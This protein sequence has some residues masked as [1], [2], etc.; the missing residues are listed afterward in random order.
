MKK[1]TSNVSR[2][3]VSLLMS[4]ALT[5]TLVTPAAFATEVV[6]G[7]GTTIV[8]GNT[9]QADANTSGDTE[10][11]PEDDEII[12]DE[13]D[14]DNGD[15]YDVQEDTLLGIS[16]YAADAWDGKT[17]D[18]TWYD[19]SKNEFE[20]STAAQLA[21]L[22]QLVNSGTETFPDKIIKLTADIDL[23]GKTWTP[24]GNSIKA[25]FAF[26]GGFYGQGHI[27]SNL[28]VPDTYC[29]G[30][31]GNVKN[32]NSLIQDL[33][34][35]GTVMASEIAGDAGDFSVGG[36]CCETSG[37]IQNC[38]FYGKIAA[39]EYF[40]DDVDGY[41]GGVVGDG[42][43]VNCWF[44]STDAGSDAGVTGNRTATNCY[45]NVSDSAKGE[46]RASEDFVNGTVVGLLNDNL[47]EGCK[48]WVQG[49]E[50]PVF[51][52]ADEAGK[53]VILVPFFPD[54]ACAGRVAVPG[55]VCE[56]GRYSVTEDTVKLDSSYEDDIYITTDQSGKGAKPL[57]PNGYALTEDTTF[58][59][60][61]KD[62]FDATKWYENGSCELG[63][64][65]ELKCF[66]NLVNRKV[67]SFA[68][69][70]IVLTAD[71]DLNNAAWTP[72]GSFAS[73]ENQI[74]FEGS[75]NGK[76][77]IVSGLSATGD[78]DQALFGYVGNSTVVENLIVI[79]TVA[80]SGT[81]R[82]A[83]I[84]ARNIGDAW[85]AGNGQKAIVQNCGFYGTVTAQEASNGINSGG[86]VSNCWYYYTGSDE[87]YTTTL[88]GNQLNC[89]DSYTNTVSTQY[90]A[91]TITAEQFEG[92]K[93]V[94]DGKT[95]VGLLNLNCG[96]SGSEWA[97]GTDYPVFAADSERQGKKL[98]IAPLFPDCEFTVSVE[99]EGVSYSAER[100]VYTITN[101]AGLVKLTRSDGKKDLWVSADA[102]GTN[103]ARVSD[104]GY[105]LTAQRTTLYYGT[106][107]DLSADITWW[108][109]YQTQT[110]Y[111]IY[112][113]AALRGIARLVNSGMVA[114]GFKGDLLELRGVPNA[115]LDLSD[116]DYEPIGTSDHPFRGSFAGQ[117]Y[118]GTIIGTVTTI[119]TGLTISGDYANVGL[120]GVVDS[121]TIQYVTIAD[122]TTTKEIEKEDGTKETVEVTVPAGTVTGSGNVGSIV[123]WL[124][125]GTVENCMS[126]AVV[127]GSSS[128]AV[129]GGLVGLNEGT[130]SS[131][132]YYNDEHI[133]TLVVGKTDSENA[134]VK[135]CFYL[136]EDGESAFGEESDTGARVNLEFEVG[137]VTYELNG[138]NGY[139]WLFDTVTKRPT[140]KTTLYTTNV[141]QL[142]L[143]AEDLPKDATAEIKLGDE[144]TIVLTK[145]NIQ[146]IYGRPYSSVP[147]TVESVT[148]GYQVVFNP[149]P[150]N[151]KLRI[152][153]D[154]T[155][156]L[157][158]ADISW[159]VGHENDVEY[160]LTTASQLEGFAIL[161]NGTA[162]GDISFKDKTIKLGN[163]IEL[164]GTWTPIG[165][166]SGGHF[167]E[168]TFDGQKHTIKGLRVNTDDA[169]AGLFG[170]V[171]HGTVKNL[172]VEGSVRSISGTNT[173]GIV[174]YLYQG[175]VENCTNKAEVTAVMG[176]VG[177][178]VGHAY[179]GNGECRIEN[180]KNNAAVT[181]T[182]NDVNGT[183]VG[184]IVGSA[185]DKVIV[186]LCKN[187][188]NVTASG[189]KKV[190]ASGIGGRRVL[191]SHNSGRVEIASG[192]ADYLY[193]GGI[194]AEGFV[195]SCQNDG[196]VYINAMWNG[197]QGF[198]Y[199]GGI[200]GG[201]T[202][203]NSYNTAA[204]VN[205]FTYADSAVKL[206]NGVAAGIA[207]NPTS[208]I[209][210]CYNIGDVSST[211]GE[212]H[213]LGGV[214]VPGVCDSGAENSYYVCKLN[215]EE[216]MKYVSTAGAE[217]D[218]AYNETDKTYM[219]GDK[220]LVD[221][222]NE[223][224]S[225]G[226]PWFVNAEKNIILPTFILL[227]N[228]D[229]HTACTGMK[230]VY[231][232]YE[233]GDG[234]CRTATGQPRKDTIVL[235]PDENGTIQPVSYT[236]LNAEAAGVGNEN[237]TF[238]MWSDGSS[239]YDAGSTIPLSGG[240]D[241]ITL[242]ATNLFVTTKERINA[243]VQQIYLALGKQIEFFERA[244]RPMEA[245]R[246]KQRVEYDLEM[247]KE[248]GYCPGIENYSRY[249]DGRAAGTRP[250][251]LIDYFPKDYLMVV[252]E[253]HVTLPQVHA[254]FGGDR[255]RKENLVEYGFRLPA[256][257]DNRPLTFSEF[258]QLQGTS[259]YVSATPA[260]YELMK[261]EGVIVEQLI[262]PT[263]LVDP[264][265]EVRV[266]LNQ[267][268]DLIGEI[269]KR[270]KNDDKVLVTTIT[271]RMAEE[272]SK[273]FDR[274]GVRNRYIHS[275][276]D[277]LERIQ[278][279]EDLR[280]GMFD[281]LV[282]VN[283]LREGLDLPEVALVAILDADKEG[284]LRNVRSLTQI[285]GRAAR[286]SQGNVILYADTCTDSMRYAIEQS[287]RRREKQVR[288]NMEHEML[289]RQAQKSG[290][291]QS[292]LLAGRVDTSEVN[293]TAYPIAEDHYAAAADVQKN[294]TAS[295]NIDAL[296]DKAREEMERAAK[297]LDF[298]AAA[299]F[300]DRMY[301]LQKL[302]EE[303]RNQNSQ[304]TIHN[305]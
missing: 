162:E 153:T 217:S 114:D 133:G 182:G 188:G 134:G 284:F 305:S 115:T 283:L 237:G 44:Y 163:D 168:G 81:G 263:G 122:T 39:D 124:Q 88:S 19:D 106:E 125:S 152:G 192:T 93:E 118:G 75:F 73:R 265:L 138:P 90:G 304:F 281:V 58:Y 167:F 302:R 38:G 201:G 288:Y 146:Y 236:V 35:T 194:S 258:E 140:L 250:F 28:Y 97:Q 297:S 55:A 272:L 175:T 259:I 131:S 143:T 40:I 155:Y 282:G 238:Q 137:R 200:T 157:T 220:L 251:C 36:V 228:G 203:T 92:Q 110:R 244:G 63:T 56:N 294:Y 227:W 210:N 3:V 69:K 158:A 256:A 150:Q 196:E 5:L 66:A 262:R 301:E 280:A 7:S 254:M 269:D 181:A 117:Y 195:D 70:T 10:G 1:R 50:Y 95:L 123:G 31:F 185:S 219:V 2:R 9:N 247:I 160:T 77:H 126:T 13:E 279:L 197:S 230:I 286:H 141:S 202:V 76:G 127:N 164:T 174:G 136:A 186:R 42:K 116:I 37:V 245:Q 86:S 120:F 61:T 29:P 218:V 233:P 54:S 91:T 4:M 216:L 223:N 207:A 107:A 213:G 206:Q 193:A 51:P 30:L 252:D 264:P 142:T 232:I 257:K 149:K 148:V 94:K 34:V 18:I 79:G 260:D 173:A 45:Q 80:A 151:G 65:L 183:T 47:P 132:Y 224:G 96:E 72:I 300:R 226:T 166:A 261:S 169:Y 205:N 290:S 129:V 191:N 204:V 64:A 112:S 178:V 285:A 240:E 221:M 170:Y 253:S 103:G 67:D 209:F 241:S 33:V 274:V 234:I 242:Y 82:A 23:G 187:T 100:G 172:T 291:G 211:E 270:V 111:A 121:G 98:M 267:I 229:Q 171:R 271:K 165:I 275:D 25:N 6:D 62:E 52:N 255:A 14:A 246:I 17:T 287:N 104:E 53:T 135:Q 248:L 144:N 27:I 212:T 299:K 87:N 154:Y 78:G 273:Y 108:Y 21:G 60:G 68:G 295:E 15:I 296:I 214:G 266:T 289:P 24:I 11:D 243:A 113:V 278:I 179:E 139:L 16:L 49:T 8:E 101:D 176:S 32:T 128:A 159:Y 190:S 43:A 84:V 161:V 46:Y 277:T 57:D 59:Y 22:A 198:N 12:T 199:A 180:C 74:P 89:R 99:G 41:R 225:G 26:K 147:V 276:V 20:I 239:T 249:F 177:G 85:N 130:V 268:D 48:K 189:T 102:S 235:E 231:V 109:N 71:I 293:M 119:I 208:S 292:A 303:N 145:G 83:G 222:L 215:G 184:G 298:L 156:K 105:T